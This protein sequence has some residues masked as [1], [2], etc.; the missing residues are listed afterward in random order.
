MVAIK[1]GF[2]KYR[3]PQQIIDCSTAYG[4]LG[5]NGGWAKYA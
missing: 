5:C 4:N 1:T 2:N 3:S